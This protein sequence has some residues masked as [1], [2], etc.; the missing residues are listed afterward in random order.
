LIV[1]NVQ[2]FIFSCG[3]HAKEDDVIFKLVEL[4]QTLIGGNLNMREGLPVIVSFVCH[5]ASPFGRVNDKK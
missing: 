2:Y 5:L 1:G 3:Q 4:R